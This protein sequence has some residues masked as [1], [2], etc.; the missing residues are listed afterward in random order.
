MPLSHVIVRAAV[1][2]RARGVAAGI[3]PLAVAFPRNEI[4]VPPSVAPEV[5]GRGRD[6]KMVQC[7]YELTEAVGGGGVMS[8][9]EERR[10][11]LGW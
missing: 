2:E 11:Y 9:T 6:G 10:V 4:E 3:P 7:H 8:C 1:C 5:E